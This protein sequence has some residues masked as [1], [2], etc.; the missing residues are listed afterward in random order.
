M[1]IFIDDL[2]ETINKTYARNLEFA[3]AN[4]SKEIDSLIIK[5][6]NTKLNIK[7]NGKIKSYHFLGKEYENDVVYLY[8]ESENI[9]DL[10]SIEI[11]NNILKEI[12]SNQK[13][14]IK[15]NMLNTKKTFFLTKKN[16]T[17]LLTL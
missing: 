3:T 15:I 16:D 4:E 6:T 17:D 1:R 9:K 2:E 11:K 8:I 7:I 13:N 12:F 14:I 5:Y 10:T